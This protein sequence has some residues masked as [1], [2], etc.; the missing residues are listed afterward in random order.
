MKILHVI[1]S[2]GPLRGGPSFAV[3]SIASGL[4]GC[5]VETHVATTDDNGPGRR[6]DVEI[7]C[8][9]KENGATYWYFP[10]QSSFYLYSA[11]FTGWMWRHAADYQLIHIHAVFSYC[12]NMAAYIASRLGVPYVVRPLGVLNRWGMEDRRPW[13]KRLS[14]ALIERHVLKNAAFIHYTAEQER[15]EAAQCGFED[16]PMIIPNPVEPPDA[17]GVRG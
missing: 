7:G 13:L 9:R 1:P 11:P 2:V 10:R 8:P 5:G 12:S 14:F 3:R 17:N 16:R 15:A 6:L 4:A